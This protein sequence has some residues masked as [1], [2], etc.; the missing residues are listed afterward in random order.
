MGR[1]FVYA[2]KGDQAH[3][4]ADAAAARKIAPEIDEIF[5]NYGLKFDQSPARTAAA[6]A[7]TKAAPADTPG[8]KKVASASG[9]RR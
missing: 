4:D 1:A 8:A 6:K 9:T 3:A 2:S 5:A 7:G